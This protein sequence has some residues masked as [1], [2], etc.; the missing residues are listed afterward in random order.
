MLLPEKKYIKEITNSSRLTV[1]TPWLF[2][3]VWDHL[4]GQSS[5]SHSSNDGEERLEAGIV[6]VVGRVLVQRPAT[7]AKHW[8]GFTTG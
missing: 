8:G 3:R 7:E 1:K 2:V 6:G 4:K 5:A